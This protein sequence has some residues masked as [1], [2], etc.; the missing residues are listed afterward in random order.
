QEHEPAYFY[1]LDEV[2]AALDKRNSE[3][4][5]SL[6]RRYTDKAQYLIISHN[7]GVISEA[8]NLYGVSMDNN[9]MSKVVSLRI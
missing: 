7:D 8:D 9:G 6:V 1:V 5:A 2:D 3:R 4:L